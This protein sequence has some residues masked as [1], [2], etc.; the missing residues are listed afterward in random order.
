MVFHQP[1]NSTG[2]YSFNA[3][4]YDNVSFKPHFH[5]NLELIYVFDGEVACTA[6]E[7]STVLTSG[8]FALI[9][10]NEV[11][12]LQ[13]VG[14]S[15]CWVG[16][17]SGDFV[18]AFAK[19]TEGKTGSGLAFSC[20]EDVEFFLKQQ[21]MTGQPSVYMLKGCLY[22]LCSEYEKS[23]SLIPKAEKNTLLMYAI[24]DY[25][26]ENYRRDISLSSMAQALGY[27]YH[28]LSKSFHRIFSMSFSEFLNSYRLDAALTALM[29]TNTDIAQIALD[30]GFQSLRSF[31]EFFRARTG[32][33]P[34]KYRQ[35][36]AAGNAR[37]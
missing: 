36:A 10:S 32:T 2:N 19:K 21:L 30:S 28:Y 22:A 6:A 34:S 37:R 26:A 13:S 8:Q 33:T 5:K 20:S 9:L 29:E 4:L 3:Y 23:I 17:F 25:I 18:H 11:H 12:S 35:G 15:R 16:V 27:N 31:N 14:D 7:K 1:R 24:T